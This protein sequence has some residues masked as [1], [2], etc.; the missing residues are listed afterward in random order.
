MEHHAR[1]RGFST[2]ELLV[3]LSVAATLMVLAL[4]P[5]SES[6]RNA[7]LRAATRQISGDLRQARSTAVGTGWEYRIVG[8]SAGASGAHR[9][10]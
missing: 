2:L 5:L 9:N 1:R 6:L 10:Q 4:P 7:R 8:F 3:A